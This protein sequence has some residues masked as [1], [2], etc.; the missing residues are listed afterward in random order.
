MFPWLLAFCVDAGAAEPPATP[1]DPTTERARQLFENGRALY[2][3]G[4][5]EGAI[6]AWN[7]AYELSK[8]PDLLFNVSSAYEKLGD[9]A[10]AIDALNRY[11][12]FATPEEGETITRKLRA[13]EARLAT[14]PAPEPQPVTE[15]PP[16]ERERPDR[17]T[18]HRIRWAPISVVVL[19]TATAV[20]AGAVGLRATGAR[21]DILETCVDTQGGLLCPASVD[22][23]MDLYRSLGTVASI[24]LATGGAIALTGLGVLV[25]S[26]PTGETTRGVALTGRF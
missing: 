12:V 15:A 17:E 4:E 20:A 18:S 7:A 21:A 25:F 23:T 11:R 22:P 3:E 5:Y 16:E 26:D 2:A 9:Y 10:A 19:G 24:G 8:L 6:E 1:A 13:L 14:E